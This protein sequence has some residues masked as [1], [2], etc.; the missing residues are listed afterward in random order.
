VCANTPSALDSQR[1]DGHDFV[2]TQ[3]VDS[4][5]RVG[6]PERCLLSLCGAQLAA[7]EGVP[8]EQ[9]VPAE[10]AASSFAEA[11]QASPMSE[12]KSLP[13][14]TGSV[15]KLIRHSVD[16]WTHIAIQTI[17]SHR[18][19]VPCRTLSRLVLQ[20]QRVL[21]ALVF[22]AEEP[23]SH[24]IDW[25][26]LD[27]SLYLQFILKRSLDVL[28]AFQQ[29]YTGL[30]FVNRSQPAQQALKQLGTLFQG[31]PLMPLSEAFASLLAMAN[32]AKLASLSGQILATCGGSMNAL[33]SLISQLTEPENKLREAN[34]VLEAPQADQETAAGDL[35]MQALLD[36]GQACAM[37]S[38]S[39]ARAAFLEEQQ[40]ATEDQADMA[41][42]LINPVFSGGLVDAVTDDVPS[43]LV[44]LVRM[45]E[46]DATANAV[47]VISRH[48]VDHHR[49]PAMA[50]NHPSWKALGSL[51]AVLIHHLQLESEFEAAMAAGD[52]SPPKFQD[53]LK[54][55]AALQ[56]HL[57]KLKQQH[58]L[59]YEVLLERL[60][61]LSIF[62]A[63]ELEPANTSNGEDHG[64]RDEQWQA[65][66]VRIVSVNDT[67]AMQTLRTSSAEQHASVESLESPVNTT[68][69][70]A[71]SELDTL[72]VEDDW[73]EL[74]HT[75]TQ[76]WLTSRADGKFGIATMPKQITELALAYLTEPFDL[77]KARARLQA[78]SQLA[79]RRLGML[80]C[81]GACL[82]MNW[83]SNM[84][85]ALMCGLQGD[86]QVAGES[87][88]SLG[89]IFSG[90]ENTSSKLRL[91]L[92]RAYVKICTRVAKLL[93]ATAHRLCE[94]AV[95]AKDCQLRL[96]HALVSVL[97]Q[98][99]E[100]A[101]LDVLLR[102]SLFT[103]MHKIQE[104]LLTLARLEL[105]QIEKDPAAIQTQAATLLVAEA[106]ASGSQSEVAS[107][108]ASTANPLD[109]DVSPT[110]AEPLVNPREEG[111]SAFEAEPGEDGDMPESPGI[112][113]NAW[114]ALP[115]TDGIE[116][117][118][119]SS[120]PDAAN[121][122]LSSAEDTSWA[123]SGRRG[124]HWILIKLRPHT[125][126]RALKIYAST[127][128]SFAPKMV[129]VFVGQRPD[130]LQ[131]VATVSVLAA[132]YETYH[133]DCIWLC[134]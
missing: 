41:S 29:E 31:L 30:D 9:R 55:V 86:I 52:L 48:L 1:A 25:T 94:P 63:T 95:V 122:M 50:Q 5:I 67:A 34:M 128:D 33:V 118:E 4:L 89:L 42:F 106:N 43:L 96:L 18:D 14:V 39:C 97:F 130:E 84:T 79:I 59:S 65:S 92:R 104:Q 23:N 132:S 15:L 32:T 98:R 101:T 11:F 72:M 126:I 83:H 40:V 123:S 124:E 10:A 8:Y 47:Q 114:D 102:S 44:D 117:L 57:L 70:H 51:F 21:F 2:V 133:L 90:V 134:R 19:L 105:S 56:S 74:V 81:F 111:A 73:H 38:G 26:S 103:D 76:S 75:A 17:Q 129:E 88:S 120:R 77:N 119:V 20:F 60:S 99:H 24:E 58:L 78:Q 100:A 16:E 109:W 49:L 6:V 85:F 82:E 35:T 121:K 93:Q 107:L 53:A 115:V 113:A 108:P 61:T 37:A 62:L 116:S 71:E 46:T 91:E 27:I 112:E 127:H 54:A 3:V 64:N 87:K 13:P 12:L 7:S 69:D 22:Q 45:T 66:R 80:R 36:L 125:C 28:R 110:S 131:R 68:L